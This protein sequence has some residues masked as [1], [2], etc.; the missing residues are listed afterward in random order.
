MKSS[1][2]LCATAKPE[3]SNRSFSFC[4]ADGC[5]NFL[6]QQ[7]SPRLLA[8]QTPNCCLKG[9]KQLQ[10][11]KVP[12]HS[13]YSHAYPEKSHLFP[14]ISQQEYNAKLLFHK[15]TQQGCT[16]QQEMFSGPCM[17]IPTLQNNLCNFALLQHKTKRKENKTKQ[18]NTLFSSV[19]C[20]KL[21]TKLLHIFCAS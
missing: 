1:Q 7:R 16:C 12:Q 15:C 17:Q 18:K 11:T 14:F 4:I 19:C 2:Q 21:A 10:S 3:A 20:I 8:C 6:P 5:F 9:K 13:C